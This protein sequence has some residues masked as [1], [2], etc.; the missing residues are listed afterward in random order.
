MK[1]FRSQEEFEAMQRTADIITT[2]MWWV[3]ILVVVTK[4]MYKINMEAI[5][6]MITYAQSVV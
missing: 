5:Q 2:T 3:L 1:Q 4:V 6:A